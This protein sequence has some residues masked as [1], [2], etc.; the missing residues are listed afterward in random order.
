MRGSGKPTLLTRRQ[1]LA[2]GV[3]L[4]GTI[5]FLPV[6]RASAVPESSPAELR[7]TAETSIT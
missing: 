4:A 6:A 7:L 2:A 5:P 1:I 3:V